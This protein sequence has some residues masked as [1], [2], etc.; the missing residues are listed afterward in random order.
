MTNRAERSRSWRPVVSALLWTVGMLALPARTLAYPQPMSGASVAVDH[1]AL[2]VADLDTSVAFYGQ[3]LGL[4]EIPSAAQGRC[5]MALGAAQLHLLG[6]RTAPVPENRE[7]HV[8]L[9]T[10]S[11]EPVMAALK[12][13]GMNWQDFA[14]NVG[15]VSQTR[16]DGVRQ[17]FFRDPDG[18]WI[19]INDARKLAKP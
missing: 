14:G 3:V 11:L 13:R 4:R 1:I 2:H 6:G 8:A 18:Y 7:R 19:E 17:I 9:T 16:S 15:Q 10:D 12:A 5:W